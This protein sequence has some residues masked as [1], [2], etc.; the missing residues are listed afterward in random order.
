MS[1]QDIMLHPL[2]FAGFSLICAVM[3]PKISRLWEWDHGWLLVI[4]V[5]DSTGIVVFIAALLTFFKGMTFENRWSRNISATQ[6]TTLRKWTEPHLHVARWWSGQ[7][8]RLV[9]I[10]LLCIAVC[11]PVCLS[12]CTEGPFSHI[13]YMPK[14]TWVKVKVTWVSLFELR[15]DLITFCTLAHSQLSPV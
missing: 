15:F 14:V 2:G 9:F 7:L 11:L 3:L 1:N 4:P 13:T 6:T 5:K 10:E 12:V 8:H